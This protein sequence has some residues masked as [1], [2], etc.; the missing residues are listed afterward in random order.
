MHLPLKPVCCDPTAFAMLASQVDALE[1][2]TA[3]I[4]AATAI[5]RHQIHNADPVKTTG[6]IQTYADRVIARVRGPQ[7]Q[8]TIA[9]LHDILFEEEGFAGNADNYY[10]P[11]NS[12]LPVVLSQ[13]KGLPITLSLVYKAVAE[14]LGIVAYGVGMPGHFLVGVEDGGEFPMLVDAF[15]GGKILT[16]DEAFAKLTTLFGR[17]FEWSADYMQPVSNRHWLT[18][19]LQNL[20]HLFSRANQFNDVAAVLEMEMLLWPQQDHLQRDLAL[21]LARNGM[22]KQASLW[23]DRY[24]S[25]HPDDPQ[26]QELRQLLTAIK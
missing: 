5:A 19:M 24:L 14:R 6:K 11:S 25:N 13:R 17:E 3:L 7:L 22:P 9:H 16:R 10:H 23:L 1:T 15:A 2:P 26:E 21:V 8:A 18:R 12:Y 20:L 4:T